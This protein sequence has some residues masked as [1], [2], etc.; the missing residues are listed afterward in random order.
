VSV[1]GTLEILIS[2]PAIYRTIIKYVYIS[3][4]SVLV[5]E[6]EEKGPFGRP[7]SRGKDNIGMDLQKVRCGVM[8]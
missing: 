7:R 5:G 1:Y 8:D 3:A 6:P 2:I 4:K